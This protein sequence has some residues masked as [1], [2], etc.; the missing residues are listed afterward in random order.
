MK[1]AIHAPHN[2]LGPESSF[3]YLLARY[4]QRDFSGI[5]QLRCNGM[6]SICDRDPDNSYRRP[7][8]L[9][10]SCQH[11]QTRAAAWG[12]LSSEDLSRYLSP[13]HVTET[14]RLFAS[15]S[16]DEVMRLR[17][18]DRQLW[19]LC[20]AS[21]E[22]VCRTPTVDL[23][24]KR[25]RQIARK[26]LISTLR[27]SLAVEAWNRAERCDL[28]LVPDSTDYLTAA[29]RAQCAQ[30][31][32]SVLLCRWD[33]HRRVTSVRYEESDTECD[34]P[35]MFNDVTAMRSDVDSWPREVLAALATVRN[36]LA[37]EAQRASPLFADAAAVS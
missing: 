3:L 20:R 33:L 37:L 7:L 34:C 16:D 17:F 32:I 1:V 26:L 24:N 21:F 22:R 8:D 13:A 23:H 35:L 28:L 25:H 4:L 19:D 36:Y 9:C 29:L 11:D 30:D 2:S 12:G 10:L 6:F 5:F 27:M 31:G 18:A 14:R 15:L